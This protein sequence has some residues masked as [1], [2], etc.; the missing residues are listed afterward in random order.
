MH[1]G[2][3]VAGGTAL[4]ALSMLAVALA[5][6]TSNSTSPLTVASEGLVCYEAVKSATSS[7]NTQANIE[8]AVTVGL[9]DPSCAALDAVAIANIKAEVAKVTAPAV[10]Q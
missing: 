4:A 2:H 5:G 1:S 6:C 9:K 10:A 3:I 8:A 7:A